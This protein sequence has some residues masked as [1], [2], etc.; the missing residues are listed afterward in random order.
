MKRILV[1]LPYIPYPLDSGG[2]NVIFSVI[3]KLHKEFEFSVALDIRSHGIASRPPKP[4]HS[5]MALVK[6]LEA[7]WPDVNFFLYYGQEQYSETP[8]A[9]PWYC[10]LL[11]VL[12]NSL[13]RKHKRAYTKWS[14]THP[15]GDTVRANSAIGNAFPSYNAGFLRFI[16]DISRKGFDII[17]VEMH[18]YLFLG[19]LLPKD[20]RRIFV[21]H[22]LRFIRYANEIK[23]FKEHCGND[24]LAYEYAKATEIAALKSYDHIIT[25]TET[26][27]KIL[28]KYIPK[29]HITVSPMSP[30]PTDILPFRPCRDFVFI[31]SGNHFPNKD[32]MQW[33]VSEI[34]PLLRQKKIPAKIYVVGHWDKK[35]ANALAHKNPEITFTGFVDNLPKFLN[36]KISI[37]PLR[38]GSGMRIKIQEAV[39]TH[40]PFIT[41]PKGVEGQPFRHQEECLIAEDSASFAQAMEDLLHSVS[42]QEKLA[43][44]AIN[45]FNERYAPQI[46]LDIRK[47]V[48]L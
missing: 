43:Q 32:G 2:N 40:S 4:S 35:D 47:R 27:K 28:S 41:T 19:Y 34:L 24:T 9:Q 37:I 39:L 48:Y 6:Q 11:S 5:K 38:I 12:S 10:K 33:F 25:L 22:E 46:L 7:L 21:H 18:E 16:Y 36:G 31:G 29:E 8:Y 13:A 1:I 42:R 26:D 20:V 3:D 30:M 44:A 14:R 45:L 23:L 15:L 17:Q